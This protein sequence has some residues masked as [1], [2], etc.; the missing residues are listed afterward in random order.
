MKKAFFLFVICFSFFELKVAQA[1]SDFSL[2]PK[3][4]K[5][6]GYDR[7]NW[8]FG[9]N[10]GLG[11]GSTWFSLYLAPT[12]AYAFTE[13][14]H[15]GSTLGINYYQQTIRY[16]NRLTNIPE[17]Y[18]LKLPVYSLSTFARYHIANMLMVSVEPQLSLSKF[19]T[20]LNNFGNPANFNS[21]TG[22][23]VEQK[24]WAIL[25]SFWVGGGYAQR[26][27]RNAYSFMTINYDL[28]QN[29]NAIIGPLDFR[30]GV[31]LDLFNK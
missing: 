21:S 5:V 9:P 4:K 8:L 26:F 28:V 29:P 20:N 19:V 23:F 10:I 15:V 3:K 14:F 6:S 18:R 30:F 16:S 27:G 24:Q 25:P 2:M 13:K 1:H 7:R 17:R 11:G 22:K 31:M 12:M